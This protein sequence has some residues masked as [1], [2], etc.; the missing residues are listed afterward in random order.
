MHPDHPTAQRAL[1]AALELFSRRGYA[2]VSMGDVAGALGIKAPS[3]YKYFAGKEELYAA[4]L[5]LL[6]RHYA[7][8]WASAAE[9]QSQLER[10]LGPAGLL[11]SGQLERETFAWFRPELDDPQAGCLRRLMALGPLGPAPGPD[12]DR[13]LWREP[14]ALY[15]GWFQRLIAREVLRRGD[16]HVMAVEYLAPLFRLLAMA[17]RA[18]PDALAEEALR[19]I[20]QF[21]RIFAL[22]APRPA[23]RLF[24]R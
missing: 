19:H 16:P 8:L 15:E 3:L 10:S 2:A 22:R 1:E 11:A 20:R 17:D 7:E 24:R 21:H 12:P 18:D 4:L 5:P 23:P 13:W 6:D 9:A 14:L